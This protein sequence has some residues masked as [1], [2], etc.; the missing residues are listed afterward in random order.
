MIFRYWLFIKGDK[1]PMMKVQRFSELRIEIE[2]YTQ[3][4]HLV[5]FY[6]FDKLKNVEISQ[7]ECVEILSR[8]K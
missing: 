2:Y 6:V 3:P 5:K 1:Y 8:I 7:E 4:P